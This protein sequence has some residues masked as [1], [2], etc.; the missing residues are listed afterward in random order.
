MQIANPIYD[1]VFKHLLEDGEIASKLLSLLLEVTVETVE[2]RG[3]EVTGEVQ[4][5]PGEVNERWLRV[6]RMDFVATV[7]NDDGSVKT[8]LIELQRVMAPDFV[9]R[10]RS[11]LGKAY[12]MPRVTMEPQTAENR[13][14]GHGHL[15]IVAVYFFGFV[16]GASFPKVFRIRRRYVHYATQEI[17]EPPVE[18]MEKLTHDAVVVQIP[19]VGDPGDTPLDRILK[20]FDQSKVGP[21]PHFIEYNEEDD[22]RMK[23]PFVT[24]I[25][26]KLH[27]VAADPET[28]ERMRIEDELATYVEELDFAYRQGLEAR[29]GEEEAK[30]RVEVERQEKE[31]A[32]AAAAAAEKQM[33]EMKVRFERLEALL[34]ERGG[35]PDA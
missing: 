7:R 1:V 2:A 24:V 30:K 8:V 4:V 33:A 34:R 28:K 31:A 12:S 19:K 13:K 3:H 29:K 10:F 16:L 14:M 17:L 22:N 26:R 35:N 6:Y 20:L 11:Y 23:D 5:L 32:L 18:A 27:G 15:P 25:A 9:G 21:D